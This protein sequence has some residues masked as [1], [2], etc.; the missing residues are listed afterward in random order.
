MAKLPVVSG[1]TLVR[2]LQRHGYV[3][4]R[5]RGSHI[6]MKQTVPPHRRAVVPND[7]EIAKGTLRQIARDAGLTID[8]LIEML[9]S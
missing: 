2:A 1:K 7:P 6:I 5:Q 9:R 8:E 3:V 4:H